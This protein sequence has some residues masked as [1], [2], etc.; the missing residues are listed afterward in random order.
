MKY[1]VANHYLKKISDLEDG[2][3]ST[4]RK[5]KQ[6]DSEKAELENAN[7]DLHKEVDKLHCKITRLEEQL[8]QYQTTLLEQQAKNKNFNE[9]ITK[10]QADQKKKNVD[11]GPPLLT[12]QN[13]KK[14][15]DVYEGPS[16]DPKI[17]QNSQNSSELYLLE[18]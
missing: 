5:V 1:F 9:Q 6:F 18:T 8:L 12:D 11:D 4:K 13:K 10:L 2:L 17:S 7:R 16:F 3:S 15:D 14:D